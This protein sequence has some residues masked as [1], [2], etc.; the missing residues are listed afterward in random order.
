MK[1]PILVTGASGNVGA[2]VVHALLTRGEPVRAAGSNPVALGA[3]F[4]GAVQ[5]VAFDFT[6]PATWQAAFEGVERIF[7]MRPPHLSNTK[8]DML[9]ALEAAKAAGVRQVTF[10]SLIGIEGAKFVPHYAVEETL[11]SSGMAWSFLRASFFMQNLNTTHQREIR[12]RSE[13]NVPV[14]S[15]RTSFIDVRDIGAVAAVTLSEEGHAGQAYDITGS[16]ALD[17]WQVADVLSK[18]L[19]RKITYLNPS[20]PAFLIGHLQ[21]R[22]VPP[23]MAVVMTGLYYSTRR[24][25]AERVT[26][27]V[28]R[29]TGKPPILF[30]QYAQDY[31]AAWEVVR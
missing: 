29:I 3:R 10:L 30:E 7:L 27:E 8:R 13:I 23:M 15:A 17:Y 18:T 28:A 6:K 12:D 24:G 11:R 9:P 2:E 14:G 26:D 16:E 20:L 5:A 31:R 4:G 25:M 22:E 1:S 21:R 19:G